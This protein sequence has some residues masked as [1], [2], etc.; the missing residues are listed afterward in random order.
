MGGGG[1][2]EVRMCVCGGGGG[3][4]DGARQGGW[5]MRRAQRPPARAARMSSAGEAARSR[6]N[7]AFRRGAWSEA[8]RHYTEAVREGA[9][10]DD[11]R[12]LGNRS[13]ALAKLGRFEDALADADRGLRARPRW[14]KGHGRRGTALFYLARFSEAEAAFMAGLQVTAADEGCRNG[15]KMCRDVISLGS[16][17][18]ER[19]AGLFKAG[20][21]ELAARLYE[22]MLAMLEDCSEIFGGGEE[23]AVDARERATLLSNA[24]AARSACDDHQRALQHAEACVSL[25]PGWPKAHARR[26]VACY[27]LGRHSDARKAYERALALD[28][29]NREYERAI[30]AVDGGERAGAEKADG[31]AAFKEGRYEA[32]ANAYS[33]TLPYATRG[34]AAARLLSNRSACRAKLGEW[35]GAL[36]DARSALAHAPAWPRAHVRAVAAQLGAGEAEDAYWQAARGL[37]ACNAAGVAASELSSL[38]QAR[39]DAF[40]AL[41]RWDSPRARKR[42]ARWARAHAHRPR[43]STRVFACSDLHVDTNGNIGW[44]SAIH[45]T[46]FQEDVL[47][48]A[49]DVGDTLNAVRQGLR[50]LKAKFRRVFYVPGNHD[51][52]I[53]PGLEDRD[54]PDSVCK[55]L[56]LVD[57]CDEL[58]VEVAP[59]EVARGLFVVPLYSWYSHE[60]DVDDPR[61]GRVR[62]DKF[63]K[64]PVDHL[65]AW[66]ILL[67]LN[68]AQMRTFK[69]EE[70]DRV[71]TL[72]HFL[73]RRELPFSTCVPEMAKAVGCL[74]LDE[75]IDAV[76]ADVHVYGHTHINGDS[77]A[78]PHLRPR[79]RYVQYALEGGGRNLYCVWDRGHAASKEVRAT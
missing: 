36:A 57:C 38:R 52:W 7:E 62:F 59:A 32:A 6:G 35:E 9:P 19:A 11:V 41:C 76:D 34:D 1:G 14:A 26:A 31:D 21:H 18:R 73:P 68:E 5:H 45:D 40:G 4:A 24:A 22:R 46:N 74:E 44:C 43:T 30:L 47:L 48:V 72:S 27:G 33:R 77:D 16:N 58:G 60:Y 79:R 71:L 63:C 69:R 13:A 10:V 37:Q 2:A 8:V 17:D 61:P 53:R 50:A 39:S 67:K 3:G 64:W 65:V 75:Q 23:D 70:G 54:F 56:S 15:L 51:L 42:L 78:F 49:G 12:P 25:R 66:K 28:P 20:R 29:S 55:L